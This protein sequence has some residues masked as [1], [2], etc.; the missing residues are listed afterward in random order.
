MLVTV[1]SVSCNSEKTIRKT[2]ESVLNQTY[3]EIEY[4]IVDGASTDKTVEIA[5]SYR[6]K[7]EQKGYILKIVSEPDKGMYDALNKGAKLASGELVGQINTDDW[8]EED[9]VEKMAEF[10]KKE[11]YD[12]AWGDLRIVRHSGDIIKKAKIGKLWT[13]TGWC[14]PSMFSKREM[15]LKYPYPLINMYDDFDYITRVYK[16]NNKVLTINELISNFSLGG[17][18]TKNTFKDAMNRVDIT[19]SIYKRH[20]MSKFY[21]FH[22]L[23]FETAKFILDR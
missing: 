5:E 12:V 8:Y 9:A 23:L 13:T 2:I 21:Y 20:G 4:I 7:F 22:R 6:D 16:D 18:S 1:I 14:H 10:Y 17:M 11:N 15:L 3:D 19:Y